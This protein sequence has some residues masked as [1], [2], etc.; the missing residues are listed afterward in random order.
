MKEAVALLKGE[1]QAR[2]FFAAI[3]QSSL[4][5]G[6]AYVALLLIAYERYHSPWAIS[7]I[8]LA[9]FVPSMFLGPVL[10]A[11]ADRWSRRW[12]AVV[13]DIVRAVAFIGIALVSS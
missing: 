4:G 7:L 10:G 1:P 9:E 2:P 6:A 12:C 5:T 13:A 11:A 3:A 8:L